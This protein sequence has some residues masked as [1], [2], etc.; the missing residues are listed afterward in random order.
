MITAGKSS[1]IHVAMHRVNY[2]NAEDW[3]E[4]TA[5]VHLNE[6]LMGKQVHTEKEFGGHRRSWSGEDKAV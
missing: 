2:F 5:G 3:T 1:C 4:A 6:V